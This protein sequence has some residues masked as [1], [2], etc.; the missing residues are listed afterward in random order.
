MTV[1]AFGAV[2]LSADLCPGQVFP[3]TGTQPD[4]NQLLQQFGPLLGLTGTTTGTTTD[5][6]GTTTTTPTDGTTTPPTDG[7]D[8]TGPQPTIITDQFTTVTGGALQARR[9]GLMIQRAIAVQ[10]GSAM[11]SG[12]GPADEPSFFRET[13]DMIALDFIDMLTNLLS[14]LNILGSLDGTGSPGTGSGSTI[15]NAATSG[16]G[17]T[18]PIQ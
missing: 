11:P 1:L 14:S 7:T 12:A 16:Q 3:T 4:I 15:P 5:T 8:G 10:S 13:F 2:A 9:P 18:V 6:T 17:T